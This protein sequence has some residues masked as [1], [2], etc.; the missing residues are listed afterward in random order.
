MKHDIQ[1][2]VVGLDGYASVVT[3]YLAEHGSR[4]QPTIRYVAVLPPPAQQNDPRLP[5]LR[6]QGIFVA[7]S[8]PEL[9][10]HPEL[11]AVWLP[12]PIHLHRPFTEQALAAGKAVLCEKPI[13]GSLQDVDALIRARD[14]AGIPAV[15][16]YQHTYDPLIAKLKRQLLDGVI[17]KIEHATLIGCWP[18]STQYFRRSDWPGK[19]RIGNTWVLDS[20]PHNALSHFVHLGL[21]L[22]GGSLESSAL[23]RQ[24]QA[25]LYRVNLIE[26]YDTVTVRAQLQTGSEFIVA[27][28][29]ACRDAVGPILKIHG[30][31]GT[32]TWTY[33]GVQLNSTALQPALHTP[34]EMLERFARL[35]RGLPDETRL[36]ATLETAR[37]EVFL[38]NACSEAAAIVP[39]P[40]EL[41]GDHEVKGEHFRTIPGIE[42]A[43]QR[44]VTDRKLLHETGAFKFTQ[45]AG[46]LDTTTYR[47]FHGPRA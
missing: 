16:A 18:R 35:V 5:G 14:A 31:R 42:A 28:T 43:L 3:K 23:P 22:L 34:R 1:I 10:A 45:P 11:E 6:A 12:V 17:G 2:G 21:L 36:C 25:E 7:K 33:Q 44:C 46:Q 29:H 4:I 20:P 41:T 13:T 39:I 32:L 8:L 19:I 24:V 37:A 47:E 9:L 38:I 30:T 40:R 27:M 26:N 15:V